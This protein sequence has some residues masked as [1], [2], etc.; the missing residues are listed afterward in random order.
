MITKTLV[1]NEELNAKTAQGQ[2]KLICW[3]MDFF[4]NNLGRLVGEKNGNKQNIICNLHKSDLCYA[5]F[6]NTEVS[7]ACI[8][9][10]NLL[11][12]DKNTCLILM[13]EG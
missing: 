3:G 2:T 4:Q 10:Y 9:L 13:S 8:F 7:T 1:T 6:Q 5:M 11:V 12:K